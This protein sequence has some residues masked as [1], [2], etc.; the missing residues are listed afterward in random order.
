VTRPGVLIPDETRFV[1]KGTCSVGVQR[2]HR[3]T[4]GRI[5]NSQVSVFLSYASAR[6]RALIDR[7]VWLPR[8]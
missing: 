3:G 1:K 5:E 8:S 4:A 7:R 2:Q 6:G